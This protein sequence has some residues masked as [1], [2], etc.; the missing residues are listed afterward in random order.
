[1]KNQIKKTLQL[2]LL[3]LLQGIARCS[4]GLTK[5]V[6]KAVYKVQ[7][8]L[9]PPD[10][11][12]HEIDLYYGWK[13]SL[14][15][16]WLER[17]CYNI[18]AIQMFEKPVVL[19][20][21]CGIGFY[22]HMFYSAIS[23]RIVAIDWDKNAIERAKHLHS[24][25]NITYIQEEALDYIKYAKKAFLSED[26]KY[27]N[28]IWDGCIEYFTEGKLNEIFLQIKD[29][30]HPMGIVSGLTPVNKEIETKNTY[31]VFSSMENLKEYLSNYFKNVMVFETFYDNRT[32]MYFFA[33]DGQLPYKSGWKH[34]TEQ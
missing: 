19:D 32:N 15:A 2:L 13:N 26:E 22:T 27:T 23:D 20:L 21:C 10:Y 6:Y 11:F 25:D 28:V 29:V 4:A 8:F 24:T 1:M 12:D 7:W 17:G 9:D 18:G 34:S 31:T 16:G 3:P 5:I 14:N 33:S 30:M